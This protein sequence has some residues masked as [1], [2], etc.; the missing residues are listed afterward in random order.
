MQCSYIQGTDFIHCSS[1]QKQ[2][3]FYRSTFF[4]IFFKG[5]PNIQSTINWLIIKNYDE[6][7]YWPL[8]PKNWICW[9]FIWSMNAAND[10]NIQ[11]DT[12]NKWIHKFELIN[13][14]IQGTEHQLNMTE[15]TDQNNWIMWETHL[16]IICYN[17][18]MAARNKRKSW[19]T[20]LHLVLLWY[21]IMIVKTGAPLQPP[22]S[23]FHSQT[24]PSSLCFPFSLLY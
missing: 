4:Y 2:I 18:A 15:S 22:R 13:P 8:F 19:L 5:D 10:I 9:G 6:A 17:Q 24:L 20:K 3:F 16:K 12:Q 1:M 21:I 23:P 7:S 14:E 11:A